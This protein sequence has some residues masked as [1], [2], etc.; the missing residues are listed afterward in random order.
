MTLAHC[1]VI[2]R[3]LNKVSKELINEGKN[4]T[5]NYLFTPS[6]GAMFSCT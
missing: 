1:F 3:S 4:A 2:V 5:I 6:A